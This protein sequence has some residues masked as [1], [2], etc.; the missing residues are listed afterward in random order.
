MVIPVIDPA[1]N[2][3]AFTARAL[4]PD[5]RNKKYLNTSD[6]PAFKK[7]RILYGMNYA[8]NHCAEQIILC[9][10][11][12]DAIALQAAGFENA[13]A[14][15]GTAITQEHANLLARYTKRVLINYDSD[16]AGIKA[17][18]KAMALLDQVGLEIRVLKLSGVKD[19]DEYIKMYG[20]DAFRKIIEQGTTGFAFKLEGV[21][22]RNDVSQTEGKIRAAR[23]LAEII[24]AV[25]SGVERELYIA[26]V[27]KALG[28]SAASITN[29]VKRFM[30][31]EY[32]QKKEKEHRDMLLSARNYGDRVNPDAAKDPAAAAAEETILGL[33]LEYPEHRK[34]VVSG[35]V[36]LGADDFFTDLGKRAFQRI[37][38]MEKSED[39]Y[40][41]SALGEYFEPDEMG[42]LVKI[43]QSR[44]SLSN[45]SVDVLAA[46]AE[47]LRRRRE[48][49][50]S[51]ESGNWQSEL[52]RRR[53]ELE[54]TINKRRKSEWQRRNK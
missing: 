41:F 22:A 13:V 43:D 24:A 21:L 47:T 30:T 11:A 12:M 33:L 48:Q 29:D 44:Q 14:T 10:G 4:H 23:E 46:A 39:G 34:A 37:I 25:G 38:E 7:S 5:E 15:L 35:R 26:D 50:E 42:R 19:S 2:V 27:S 54:R 32:R 18:H 6:T 36:E 51:A 8:K 40:S 45:N 16:P 28:I 20:A 3:V 17:T 52:A 53:A 49:R 1:G 9:E 31:R